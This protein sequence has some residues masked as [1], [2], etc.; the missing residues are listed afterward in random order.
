MHRGVAWLARRPPLLA[1]GTSSKMRY[2]SYPR[3]RL[4]TEPA[5]SIQLARCRVSYQ[6]FSQ[7][8]ARAEK[9]Q[10]FWLKPEQARLT[11]GA[12][13]PRVAAGCRC[14]RP[15][16]HPHL[17][18]PAA[19]VVTIC[20]TALCERGRVWDEPPRLAVPV[21]DLGVSREPGLHIGCTLVERHMGRV[22]VES[23]AGQ[24]GDGS[25]F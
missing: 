12:E 1:H 13:A 2:C 4:T 19:R 8:Q 23:E 22:G 3:E 18:G 25:T 9:Q 21:R 20:K 15:P 16:L 6:A 5:S 7:R 24:D 11:T 14:H 17:T 10:D